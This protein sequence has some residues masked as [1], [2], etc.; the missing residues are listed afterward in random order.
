MQVLALRRVRR[1]AHAGYRVEGDGGWDQ[2]HRWHKNH[3]LLDPYGPLVVRLP[4][5]K[6]R[7][8]ESWARAGAVAQC[9]GSW[10]PVGLGGSL[11][12]RASCK[13]TA[14]NNCFPPCG[15][16]Q[17]GRDKFADKSGGLPPRWLSSFDLASAPFD[18]QGVA[19]PGHA[20][21]DLVIYEMGVRHFTQDVSSG[22]P[23]HLRRASPSICSHLTRPA[24][25]MSTPAFPLRQ[26]H[27]RCT[28]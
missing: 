15:L 28:A 7:R 11:L 19:P 17:T 21:E 10:L 27:V 22:L 14:L 12:Q 24:A 2:G 25:A 23:D 16:P 26:P 13:Q 1:R 5:H 4:R 9:H 6:R 3:I 20:L 8:Q 18:W